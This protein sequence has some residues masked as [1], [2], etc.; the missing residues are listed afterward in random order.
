MWQL[1]IIVSIFKTRKFHPFKWYFVTSTVAT[2][3]TITTAATTTTTAA[4]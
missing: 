1:L 4:K 3:S 2:A